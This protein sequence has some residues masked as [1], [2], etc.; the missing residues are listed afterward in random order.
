MGSFQTSYMQDEHQPAKD[1]SEETISSST[2]SDE[3]DEQNLLDPV[4]DQV[5]EN[6][7]SNSSS[8]KLDLWDELGKEIRKN[9]IPYKNMELYYDEETGFMN[10][11]NMSKFQTSV[12]KE[13]III[14][15]SKEAQTPFMII[16]FTDSKHNKKQGLREDACSFLILTV[17][18]VPHCGF[19][20][21]VQEFKWFKNPGTGDVET[22]RGISDD[23]SKAIKLISGKLEDEKLRYGNETI[24]QC[25]GVVSSLY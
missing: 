6:E 2:E 7:E 25:V 20:Y 14:G 3:S 11:K 24:A 13:P 12:T 5:D 18:V 15:I 8:D 1:K 21:M 9:N 17:M 19:D 10:Q 16:R 23:T 4:F 22:R